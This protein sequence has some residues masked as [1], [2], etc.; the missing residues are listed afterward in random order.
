MIKF[1]NNRRMDGLTAHPLPFSL[2]NKNGNFYYSAED[3]D[4][5]Y[6]KATQIIL[7]AVINLKI[8]LM[9]GD[10]KVHPVAKNFISR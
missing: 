10:R 6:P 9:I 4:F 5:S 3:I 2:V 1:L 7:Y 8:V